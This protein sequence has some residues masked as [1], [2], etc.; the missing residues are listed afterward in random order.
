MKLEDTLVEL[1]SQAVGAARQEIVGVV[2]VVVTLPPEGGKA[3]L[4]VNYSIHHDLQSSSVNMLL[5]AANAL[6]ARAKIEKGN[7]AQ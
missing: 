5:D 4:L 2:A 7:L 1:I 3:E 6:R